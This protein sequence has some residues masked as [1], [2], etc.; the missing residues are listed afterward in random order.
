MNDIEL[1]R[2]AF[3]ILTVAIGI[4]QLGY[5]FHYLAAH[6]RFKQSCIR[7][8]RICHLIKNGEFSISQI[9]IMSVSTIDFCRRSQKARVREG[10]REL[11]RNMF[12]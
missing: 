11:V 7:Q 5:L 10:A 3:I 8:E 4:G 2:S 9:Y 12:E 1:V 6:R